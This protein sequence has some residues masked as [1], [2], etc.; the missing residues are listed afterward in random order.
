MK[1]GLYIT[2]IVKRLFRSEEMKKSYPD[3]N[4][5]I[6]HI[7]DHQVYGL[8]PSRIIYR[9][10]VNYIFGFDEKIKQSGGNDHFKM[11]D[12]AEL[13]KNGTFEEVIQ[14]EFGSSSD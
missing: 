13:T 5:R 10:A 11:I 4:E 6:R 2:E 3:G 14:K 9:T 12:A 8:A 7:L 1:S